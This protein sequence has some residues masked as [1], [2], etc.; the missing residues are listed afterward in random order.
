MGFALKLAT[1]LKG[2][3]HSEAGKFALTSRSVAYFAG[4]CF[5]L[6]LVKVSSPPSQP[7]RS[8]MCTVS[9]MV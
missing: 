4:H 9:E 2:K 5:N 7:G 8:E 3:I 6:L 1:H